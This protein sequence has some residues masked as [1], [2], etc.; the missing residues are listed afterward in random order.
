MRRLPPRHLPGRPRFHL[1]FLLSERLICQ[2][3]RGVPVHPMPSRSLPIRIWTISGLH[4]LQQGQ[5]FPRHRGRRFVLLCCLPGWDL[6]QRHRSHSLQGLP[7]RVLHHR[8]WIYELLRLRHAPL[9]PHLLL[10]CYGD[11]CVLRGQAV[12]PL[13]VSD[14]RYHRRH[15]QWQRGLPQLEGS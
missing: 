5:V 2:P 7:T 4:G 6:R 14:R 15:G 9:Y 8:P 11:L 12:L 3:Y 10:R 1:L 13:P